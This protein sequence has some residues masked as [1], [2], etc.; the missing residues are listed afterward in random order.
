MAL[1]VYPILTS[2]RIIDPEEELQHLFDACQDLFLNRVEY[3]TSSTVTDLLL[4][5]LDIPVLMIQTV[6]HDEL[7]ACAKE[8]MMK[9]I[10]TRICLLSETIE[11]PWWGTVHHAVGIVRCPKPALWKIVDVCWSSQDRCPLP[12]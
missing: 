7:I 12:M 9:N 3:M 11:D 4:S 1:Q 2:F 5:G 10:G 8:N 6:E